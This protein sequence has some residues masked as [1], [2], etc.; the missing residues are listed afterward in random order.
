MASKKRPLRA[1]AD[2]GQMH[3]WRTGDLDIPCQVASPQSL[4]PFLQAD[5]AYPEWRHSCKP[6]WTPELCL[7]NPLERNTT[8][9]VRI[10]RMNHIHIPHSTFK[11][12]LDD[13]SGNRNT[14]DCQKSQPNAEM[15]HASMRGLSVLETV[16]QSSRL[17][18]TVSMIIAA[19]LR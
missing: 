4:T 19:R 5:A 13:L 3:P 9:Y 7:K 10:S 16:H 6:H 15:R 11:P 17:Y 18:L 14:A 12:V 2:R 1:S 8:L